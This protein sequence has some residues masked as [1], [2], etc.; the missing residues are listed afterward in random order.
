MA[1]ELSSAFDII[2]CR[3]ADCKS[4]YESNI[5][6]RTAAP[7]L[8]GLGRAPSSGGKGL[9]AGGNIGGARRQLA[10]QFSFKIFFSRIFNLV[11][12]QVVNFA[13]QHF[14][15]RLM[16]SLQAIE[17]LLELPDL[18]A[19]K[20]N[21]VRGGGLR[22]GRLNKCDG[23]QNRGRPE[24]ENIGWQFHNQK[25]SAAVVLSAAPSHQVKNLA[26]NPKAKLAGLLPIRAEATQWRGAAWQGKRFKLLGFEKRET[27]PPRHGPEHGEKKN[28]GNKNCDARALDQ[29]AG[30]ALMTRPGLVAVPGAV[31]MM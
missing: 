5:H 30:N 4:P 28:R 7:D 8:D 26:G 21:L 14:N 9:C 23:C 13:A 11:F 22:W 24:Q 25:N 1:S 15:L 20:L 2:G 10:R 31:Q 12:S 17:I 16:L 19:K 27:F 6:V 29:R 18:R 3:G